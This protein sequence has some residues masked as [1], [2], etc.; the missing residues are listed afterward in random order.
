MEVVKVLHMNQG[1]GKTSYANNSTLQSKIISLA[2]PAVEDAIGGMLKLMNDNKLGIADLGCSSGPNALRVVSEIVDIVHAECVKIDRPTP[3]LNFFLN[4]LFSNDFN[5]I[6]KSLPKFYTRLKEETGEAGCFVSATP[7]SFYGRLF[8]KNSLHLVHSSS[9]LHWLSQVPAVVNKGRL[10]ISKSSPSL[11]MEAYT[12]Q[13]Q[14]DFSV[15]LSSRAEELIIG[16]HLVM[17]LM[18]RTSNDPTSEVGCH[19]QWELLAHA[20]I[21]MVADGLTN[22]E[23]LDSFNAP[24]YAPSADEVRAEVEREGSFYVD[25][26]E[27]FEVEWDGGRDVAKM[28]TRGERV[29]K[30]VRA[31]VESMIESHFGGGI[32]DEL[33]NRYAVIVDDYLSRNKGIYVNLVVSLVRH[34]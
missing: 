27:A 18:G 15:F 29:A 12:R 4:D 9:S 10:Y 26:V 25:R 24:Y 11:V 28:E 7:G 33:F 16:G 17:S 21:T 14:Q 20:L 34:V 6:F 23:K 2:K 1:N 19:Y 22:E 5:N 3:D 32:V 13:F 8:P 30:T 31:V